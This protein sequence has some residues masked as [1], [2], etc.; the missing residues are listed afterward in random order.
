MSERIIDI[1][2]NKVLLADILFKIKGTIF[3][4][5]ANPLFNNYFIEVDEGTFYLKTSNGKQAYIWKTKEGQLEDGELGTFC[6]NEG[7]LRTGAFTLETDFLKIILS[8]EHRILRIKAD[9]DKKLLFISSNNYSL[10]LAYRDP[11]QMPR[12]MVPEGLLDIALPDK[13]ADLMDSLYFSISDEAEKKDLNSLCIDINK[14][15]NGKIYFVATDRIRLS[16]GWTD[17]N[18]DIKPNRVILPKYVVTELKK[19][20]ANHM[21]LDDSTKKVY[22]R[23]D[24][25]F[26][27][28]VYQTIQIESP[29]PEI[30][31]YLNNDFPNVDSFL[32]KRTPVLRALKRLKIINDKKVYI[33][34]AKDCIK[35]VA[36][37]SSKKSEEKLEIINEKEIGFSVDFKFLQ[38]F[39]SHEE[40]EDI[41]LKVMPS[42]CIIFDRPAYRHVLSLGQ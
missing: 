18:S 14:G 15:N 22:F 31:D 29:Y 7:S 23:Q 4:T 20:N 5:T 10:D 33:K 17:C 35:L 39:L 9:L 13:F 36:Q 8:L 40:N 11:K 21:M 41:Y 34:I 24:D 32:F 27:T 30:Y 12:L 6:Y 2:I 28:L 26:G 37:S 19:I 38:E 3:S 42:N 16:S 25:L 1:S